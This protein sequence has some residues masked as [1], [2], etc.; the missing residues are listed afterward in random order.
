MVHYEVL[1]ID[2]RGEMDRNRL[3]LMLNLGN[4]IPSPSFNSIDTDTL[5]PKEEA[6]SGK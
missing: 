4:L 2:T 6:V 1:S 3:N 5:T